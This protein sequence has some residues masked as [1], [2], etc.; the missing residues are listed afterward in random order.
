M[1][2]NC[3]FVVVVVYAVL[4]EVVVDLLIQQLLDVE[5]LV[6]LPLFSRVEVVRF[7]L[8]DVDLHSSLSTLRSILSM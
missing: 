6:A 4:D 5:V 7:Y 1:F 2:S 8:D 3:C